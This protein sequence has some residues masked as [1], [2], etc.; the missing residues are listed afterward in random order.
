MA[1]RAGYQGFKKL[2]P[3]LK[4]FRPGCLGVDNAELSKIFFPRS[5]QAVLGAK[6]L[7]FYSIESSTTPQ[8]V[9]FTVNNDKTIS[10]SGTATANSIKDLR[11]YT[12]AELKALGKNLILS[13]GVS[14]NAYLAIRTSDF[15]MIAQSKGDDVHFDTSTLTDGTT[16]YETI[17]ILSGTNTTGMVIKPMISFDGGVYVP[18]AMTNRELT[19]RCVH[20]LS[21]TAPTEKGLVFTIIRKDNVVTIAFSGEATEAIS[22][23]TK[24]ISFP[25]G[26]ELALSSEIATALYFNNITGGTVGMFTVKSDGI[27]ANTN[28]AIGDKPRG[29]CTFGC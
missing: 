12:G 15:T 14:N 22:N 19:E 20:D 16:Y 27:Y 29:S 25:Q 10:L 11:T 26:Y 1:L 18:P 28:I 21:K 6:N 8:G 9:T 3:G 5:E 7:N 17:G 24:I 2:L 4:L 23:A 13:G